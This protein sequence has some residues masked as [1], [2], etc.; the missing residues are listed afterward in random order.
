MA[1]VKSGTKHAS[2]VVTIPR[3][4]QIAFITA[5][6]LSQLVYVA[7]SV[8]SF[9]GYNHSMNGGGWG[10][11]AFQAVQ[12]AYPILFAVAGY[13]FIR[14]RVAGTVPRWFWAL[15]LATIALIIHFALQVPINLLLNSL[16]QPVY[17]SNNNPGWWY[18]FGWM[19][20]EMAVYFVLFC[21]GLAWISRRG[22]R[23]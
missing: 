8:W 3:P 21:G 5:L 10:L 17:G 23:A 1:R 20:A 9:F 19:W 16:M 18:N 15:F 11:Q 4:W 12:F 22:K 2:T 14:R 6:V 13:V 7:L